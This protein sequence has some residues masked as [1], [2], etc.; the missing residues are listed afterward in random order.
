MWREQSE[1]EG[2]GGG[3]AGRRQGRAWWG[4]C[5]LFLLDGWDVVGL[6]RAKALRGW[7]RL[8]VLSLDPGV[9]GLNPSSASP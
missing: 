7:R 9:K 3:A 4:G 6:A 8:V 5:G 2:S 1:G